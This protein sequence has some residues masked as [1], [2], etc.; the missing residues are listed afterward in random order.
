M[1]EHSSAAGRTP[2]RSSTWPRFPSGPHR[3]RNDGR[4]PSPRAPGRPPAGKL[5]AG[6]VLVLAMACG[7]PAAAAV[8]FAAGGGPGASAAGTSAESVS[9][10]LAASQES[11]PARLGSAD[12]VLGPG[13]WHSTAAGRTWYGAY[14]TLEDR[15]AYCVDAGLRTPLPRHFPGNDPEERIEAPE[16]AWALHTQISSVSVDVHAALSALVKL[17]EAI[18][19][20]HAITPQPLSELGTAFAG[21]AQKQE[22]FESRAQ[23]LAGPYTLEVELTPAAGEDTWESSSARAAK[24]A[25]AAI[26]LLSASGKHLSGHTVE[27]T[28]SGGQVGEHSVTTGEE[29]TEVEVTELEPGTVTV[30]V[31]AGDLP[32]T[33]VELHRPAGTGTDRV[34]SVVTAG[35]PVSVKAQDKLDVPEP[36]EVEPI[37]LPTV[38]LPPPEPTREPDEEPS[39][40]TP[41]P[42]FTADV[43]TFPAE[44]TPV[45]PT[46][47]EPAPDE[48]QPEQPQPEQPQPDEPQPEK[49]AGEP[50]LAG[51]EPE[52]ETASE[53]TPAPQAP[54]PEPAAPES[55][56][57]EPVSTLPHT[58]TSTRLALGTALALLGVGGTA[59]ILT[60]K[61]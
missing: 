58:G 39:S 5:L 51:N 53:E 10:S 27:V 61:R 2:R 19:H 21:A 33:T 54:A 59:L 41:G 45:Q 52:K 17:D 48:P 24:T 56:A 25:K 49:S 60:R 18:P 46:P 30:E 3:R 22:E 55:A 26:S 11:A 7:T 35:G 36:R 37:P 47:D 31:V 15:L 34:Q 13:R 50:P 8:G 38:T 20:R 44:P 29:P 23:E 12:D 42:S 28:A 6:T 57:P 4:K 14:R 40:P 43:P 9:A 32:A 1:T 16:T